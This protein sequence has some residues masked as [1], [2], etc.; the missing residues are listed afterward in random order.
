MALWH[1]I[2]QLGLGSV[3]LTTKGRYAVTAMIDIALHEHMWPIRLADTAARQHVP[4]QYLEQLAAKLRQA[5]L[6]QS[7]RGPNGGYQLCRP[8]HNITL[9]AILAAAEEDLDVTRCGGAGNCQGGSTCLTHGLW[10]ELNQKIG[11]FLDNITLQSLCQKSDV[12]R[13]AARQDAVFADALNE[14]CV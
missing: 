11:Q 4:L 12:R 7:L 8:A 14:A 10:A 13:V 5:G 3:R 9:S 1:Q 6:L 2:V